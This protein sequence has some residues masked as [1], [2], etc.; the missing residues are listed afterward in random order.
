M[1]NFIDSDDKKDQEKQLTDIQI[2]HNLIKERNK[3]SR[4]R[5]RQSHRSDNKSEASMHEPKEIKFVSFVSKIDVSDLAKKT[6]DELSL[7]LDHSQQ[8]NL[9]WLAIYIKIKS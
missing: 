3:S 5:S 7:S 1:M 9:V 6:E 2:D 4:S 8:G